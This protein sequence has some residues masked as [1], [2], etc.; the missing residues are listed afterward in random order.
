MRSSPLPCR[1]PA[2]LFSTYWNG[3]EKMQGK[4]TDSPCQN[5]KGGLNGATEFVSSFFVLKTV[6]LVSVQQKMVNCAVN[7]PVKCEAD[8]L[9]PGETDIN[10]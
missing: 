3:F 8:K 10:T 7:N 2:S 1:A 5:V 6:Q 9:H 4:I